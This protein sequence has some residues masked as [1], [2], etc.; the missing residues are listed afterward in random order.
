MRSHRKTTPTLQHDGKRY[1][2]MWAFSHDKT[3]SLTTATRNRDDYPEAI[4]KFRIAQEAVV[5]SGAKWPA[6][7]LLLERHP[8]R[9]PK[10]QRSQ[11]Q[12]QP[13][14]SISYHISAAAA[15]AAVSPERPGAEE[16]SAWQYWWSVSS[17]N[18]WH[19]WQDWHSS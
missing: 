4:F 6:Y 16:N 10:R 2:S 15:A 19:G 13:R 5:S 11:R 9:Q 17:S 18:W 1:Q 12:Q 14:T 7:I 8:Q 3:G